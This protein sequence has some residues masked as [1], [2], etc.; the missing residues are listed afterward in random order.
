M[1]K[2]KLYLPIKNARL[3]NVLYNKLEEI[4][5]DENVQIVQE[6]VSTNWFEPKPSIYSEHN[7]NVT[8]DVLLSSHSEQKLQYIHYLY[9]QYEK[10]FRHAGQF[11]TNVIEGKN[12]REDSNVD[13]IVKDNLDSLRYVVKFD[14]PNIKTHIH[15]SNNFK[16]EEYWAELRWQHDYLL[17]NKKQECFKE[18][19]CK[20]YDR[21]ESKIIRF[22]VGILS[23]LTWTLILLTI[24]NIMVK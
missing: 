13:I 19:L 3:N 18:K 4:C 23:F 14:N 10:R 21:H 6:Q 9:E 24:K 20:F 17:E 7:L 22:T 2:N 5:N 1:N 15:S 11:V 8:R 12:K 16:D